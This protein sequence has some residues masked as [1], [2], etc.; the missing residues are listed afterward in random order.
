MRLIG[1]FLMIDVILLLFSLAAFVLYRTIRHF[2]FSTFSL[3]PSDSSPIG[4]V[5][6]GMRLRVRPIWRSGLWLLSNV[7]WLTMSGFVLAEH[8]MGLVHI[9]EIDFP[10]IFAQILLS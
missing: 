4:Y 7:V 1:G 2:V 3:K 10:F 5:I 8:P 9:L 6:D